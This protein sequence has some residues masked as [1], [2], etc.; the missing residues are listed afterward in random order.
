M[1]AAASLLPD[2]SGTLDDDIAGF[3]T[4]G[5]GREDSLHRDHFFLEQLAVHRSPLKMLAVVDKD[6][7]GKAS[8]YRRHQP[9][10][11]LD[12]VGDRPGQVQ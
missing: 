9:G 8:T 7:V 11:R 4:N 5:V 2:V 1:E 10:I 3:L 6:G 12:I